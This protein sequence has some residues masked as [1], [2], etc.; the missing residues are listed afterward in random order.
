MITANRTLLQ[1]FEWHTRTNPPHYIRLNELLPKL[2]NLGITSIWLPP[3]CKANNPDGNGYDI[4]DLWD[5]GE[6]DQKG[7]RRTKWGSKE[8]LDR[9]LRT[10]KDHGI[11][12][13]WD[14]VINHKQAG[15]RTESGVWAVEVDKEGMLESFKV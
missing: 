2:A 14:A 5:L 13:V 3:G 15:D 12:V 4:Y 7:A 6:F 8:E 10:A 1:T 11:D 9:L